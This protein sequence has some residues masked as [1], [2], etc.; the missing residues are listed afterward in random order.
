MLPLNHTQFGKASLGNCKDIKFTP[1]TTYVGVKFKSTSTDQYC[2]EF[3]TIYRTDE[4][5]MY[6]HNEKIHL[7]N[8]PDYPRMQVNLSNYN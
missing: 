7:E 3:V 8:Y 5:Y 6:F 1:S 2:P 4:R